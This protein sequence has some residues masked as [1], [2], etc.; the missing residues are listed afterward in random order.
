VSI[1]TRIRRLA[2]LATLAGGLGVFTACMP[3]PPPPQQQHEVAF[4]YTGGSQQWVV[5]PGVTQAVFDVYGAEGGGTH[6]PFA[7][8][9]GRV[10]ATLP[11]TPGETIHVYVGG[12]GAAPDDVLICNSTSGGF[13][14]GGTGGRGFGASRGGSGGG[15]SDVRQGGFTLAHRVLV[16]GGGGGS[17][18]GNLSLGQGGAGGG[19][20]GAL[21]DDGTN[22][23]FVTGGNGGT[24]SFIGVGGVGG[25]GDAIGAL[26]GTGGS[27]SPTCND[28]PFY[29]G[30]GGGGGYFGGGGGGAEED[31]DGGEI[32]AAGGGGGSSFGPAGTVFH[33]GVR[34]DHGRVVITYLA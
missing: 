7:G 25:G 13:N 5:P 34:D 24:Q 4:E 2:A 28:S 29:A 15:G 26:G 11:V 14:G 3:P 30:G 22:D 1:R 6:Y 20:A 23:Q 31:P 12:A 16:G 32:H 19:P 17:G 10:T 8:R 21:G 33:K 9:G 27:N 18:M